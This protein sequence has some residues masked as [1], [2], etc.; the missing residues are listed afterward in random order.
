MADDRPVIPIRPRP[1]ASGMSKEEAKLFNSIVDSK[2]AD[3]FTP[4]VAVL[5]REMCRA[6][7]MSD[8]LAARAEEMLAADDFT[9]ARLTL[10]LRDREARRMAGLARTLRLAP[11][12]KYTPRSRDVVA[13]RLPGRRPWEPQGA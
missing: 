13:P 6:A 10:S 11:S 8:R 12:S 3:F 1:K 5:L 9:G 4:D 7:V 2:S